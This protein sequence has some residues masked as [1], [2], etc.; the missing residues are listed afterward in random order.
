VTAHAAAIP[1]LLALAATDRASPG[2]EAGYP[3][4]LA[5]YPAQEIALRFS[6]ARH[7][8]AG[9][10]CETCH[11]DVAGS[12]SAAERRLPAEPRCAACHDVEGARAGKA[13]DPPSACRDCHPGFDFTLQGAPRPSSF[14]RPALH[15]SHARHLARG[16]GCAACHGDLTQVDVA[17]RAQLPRMATCLACHDGKQAS[18]AC[19]TCHPGPRRAR[20]ARIETQ[21]PGGTLR[22]GRGDPF[23][24]DH[25]PRFERAHGSLALREREA[26]AAC[27]AES[28]C[29]RCHDGA[30]RPQDVHP[31]DFISLHPVAARQPEA[32]C[33]ACHRRQSFCAACHER[34][35]VGSEAGGAFRDPSARVHPPAWMVPGPGH[36][37][38]QAARGIGSCAS[39]HREEQCAACHAPTTLARRT[40][41]TGFA[42]RCRDMIRRSDRACAKCHVLSDPGDAAARCR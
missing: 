13:V 32:R 37:G 1:L 39:C 3:R 9:A 41:P 23:G 18:A 12:D 4:S 20:G 40:H 21:L 33:D 42:E 19:A 35:G 34:T 15:F 22:P 11:A 6:H 16:A 29:L 36:H 24:L 5:V 28:F 26:C 25:G 31:N 7:M 8:K 17:T 27:H 10:R 30:T 38:V 14:P 2:E